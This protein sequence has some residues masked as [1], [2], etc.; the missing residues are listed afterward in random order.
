M[1]AHNAGSQRNKPCTQTAVW[2]GE[3]AAGEADRACML[4]SPICP[5]GKISPV[6]SVSAL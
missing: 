4:H 5:I 2:S 3:D 6:Q 1:P